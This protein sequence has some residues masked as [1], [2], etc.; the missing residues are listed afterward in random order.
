MDEGGKDNSCKAVRAV[1]ARRHIRTRDLYL[2]PALE[3]I[4]KTLLDY[5]SRAEMRWIPS[6][7]YWRT[8]DGRP[9]VECKPSPFLSRLVT[10]TLTDARMA[11]MLPDPAPGQ[12]H[13][14]TRASEGLEARKVSG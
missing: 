13:P 9:A 1:S 11:S 4:L 6:S 5:D 10:H 2:G 7:H 3:P 12:R 14:K 8:R